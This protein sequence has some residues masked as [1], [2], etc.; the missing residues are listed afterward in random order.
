MS[1]T[2]GHTMHRYQG[3]KLHLA[4]LARRKAMT[5]ADNGLDLDVAPFWTACPLRG[6]DCAECAIMDADMWDEYHM[7]SDEERYF[8]YFA[9]LASWRRE[10]NWYRQLAQEDDQ[11]DAILRAQ[12]DR[13]VIAAYLAGASL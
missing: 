7:T 13:L 10:E 6:C 9:E 3:H 12:A 2:T 5:L 8:D 1:N 11:A 4:N